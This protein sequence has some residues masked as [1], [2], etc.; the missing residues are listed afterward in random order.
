ML[1]IRWS[2]TLE[3]NHIDYFRQGSIYSPIPYKHFGTQN[4]LINL[5]L[6]LEHLFYCPSN[7]YEKNA[8]DGNCP[9]QICN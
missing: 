4:L 3:I 1:S 7:I 5:E 2:S 9:H 6:N 8:M